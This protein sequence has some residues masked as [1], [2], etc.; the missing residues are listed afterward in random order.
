MAWRVV[1]MEDLEYSMVRHRAGLVV[2][3]PPTYFSSCSTVHPLHRL[4]P[5]GAYWQLQSLDG[6]YGL[7]ACMVERR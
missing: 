4:H 6:A 1:V 2:P 5:R 3:S 7:L